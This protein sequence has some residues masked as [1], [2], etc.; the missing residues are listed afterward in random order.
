MLCAAW[1]AG[2][3]SLTFGEN[4]SIQTKL[5]V[6]WNGTFTCITVYLKCLGDR[7][8]ACMKKLWTFKI[9]LTWLNHF[10]LHKSWRLKKLRWLSLFSP[11]PRHPPHVWLVFLFLSSPSFCPRLLPTL[12]LAHHHPVLLPLFLPLPHCQPLLPSPLLTRVV[13]S[14][15]F[16]SST[17]SPPSSLPSSPQSFLL[18]CLTIV[19]FPHR[20]DV[21]STSGVWCCSS[22]CPGWW[23]SPASVSIVR[24]VWSDL[25][26]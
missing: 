4:C 8:L 5:Y 9:T 10:K 14:F 26:A 25:T 22:G 11:L 18:P 24:F 15:L 7:N 16:F 21:S 2:Y 19:L 1:K 17:A 6:P 23:A 3:G 12:L 20:C 13:L